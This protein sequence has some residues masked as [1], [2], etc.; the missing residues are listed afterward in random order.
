MY[1]R[2]SDA[3][4]AATSRLADNLPSGRQIAERVAHTVTRTTCRELDQCWVQR[5]AALPCSAACNLKWV[6]C[7]SRSSTGTRDMASVFRRMPVQAMAAGLRPTA[8]T[9]ATRLDTLQQLAKTLSPPED[10]PVGPLR[11]HSLTLLLQS[12]RLCK[13]GWQPNECTRCP[14]LG[15][16]MHMQ[17]QPLMRVCI[18]P[19]VG[20][21]LQ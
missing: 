6:T 13:P 8:G 7:R 4:E 20:N 5:P 19:T 16:H 10:L 17:W 9:P 18:L 15:L 3:K 11:T 21:S 1:E 12:A 2:A 14:A